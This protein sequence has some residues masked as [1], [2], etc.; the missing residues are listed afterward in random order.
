M[1]TIAEDEIRALFDGLDA[2]VCLHVHEVGR[3]G[4]APVQIDADEP[5]ATASVIKILIALA[6]A[7]AVSAGTLDP[8]ELAE[9]PAR[10]RVGGIGTTGLLDPVT[11]S[12]RDLAALMMTLSDNAATDVVLDRVGREAV[13]Q[14]VADLGLEHTHLRASMEDG[15]LAAVAGLGLPHPRDL[16]DQVEQ[17]DPDAVRRLAWLDP[18]R[19]NASTA[20]EIA[21]LLDAIWTDRAGPGDACAFVRGLMAGQALTD[22]LASG[23]ALGGVRV[24]GKTG[25]LPSIRNEAGVVTYPDGRS[26]AAAVFTRTASLAPRRPEISAAIGR[27]ARI[28]VDALRS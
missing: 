2:T 26:Y 24:A 14:T 6:F 5:V 11:L 22:R 1:R 7:R 19:A 9:V 17:A 13:R 23:F 4:A 12:L 16:D 27:A 21:E 8:R 20:R 25:T 10:L 15:H 28:A 18:A 3:P